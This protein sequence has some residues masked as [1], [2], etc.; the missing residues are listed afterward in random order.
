MPRSFSLD[1]T[2]AYRFSRF[3]RLTTSSSSLLLR[4]SVEPFLIRCSRMLASVLSSEGREA[5]CLLSSDNSTPLILPRLDDLTV[6]PE[7]FVD[8]S[9]FRTPHF[10][11]FTP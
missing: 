8:L 4:E 5:F 6:F 3:F 7:T 2:S 10:I 9:L 1:V 11:P